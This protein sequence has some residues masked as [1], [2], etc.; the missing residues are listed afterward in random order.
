MVHPATSLLGGRGF[1]HSRSF[2]IRTHCFNFVNIPSAMDN[3]QLI[4]LQGIFNTKPELF[5][6]HSTPTEIIANIQ[7]YSGFSKMLHVLLICYIIL[8]LTTIMIDH[9]I[10]T[11]AFP[12]SYMLVTITSILTT[13]IRKTTI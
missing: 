7:A 8:L 1:N 12:W 4:E 13:S 9:L 6:K 10:F 11:T 5:S 3:A 2:S